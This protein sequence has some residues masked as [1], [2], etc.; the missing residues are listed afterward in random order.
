MSRFYQFHETARPVL[1]LRGI[2]IDRK[3]FQK[4]SE[5]M[6]NENLHLPVD[7]SHL[8]KSRLDVQV[9]IEITS[10]PHLAYDWSQSKLSWLSNDLVHDCKC[11]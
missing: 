9:K 10:P 8:F 4:C 11:S 2:G 3:R 6:N 1:E 7:G 5:Y